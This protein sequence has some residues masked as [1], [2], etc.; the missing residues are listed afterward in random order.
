[1]VQSNWMQPYMDYGIQG[2]G[3]ECMVYAYACILYILCGMRGQI[4]E[5]VCI[6]YCISKKDRNSTKRIFCIVILGEELGDLLQT[7]ANTKDCRQK[8]C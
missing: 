3:R 5:C 8:L 2:E 1:M 6:Q 4:L 7:V